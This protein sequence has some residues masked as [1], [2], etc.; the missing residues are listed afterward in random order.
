[1]FGVLLVLISVF[2]L[3]LLLFHGIGSRPPWLIWIMGIIGGIGL[4][5]LKQ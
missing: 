3:Y 4:F 2:Y 1:M 5:F